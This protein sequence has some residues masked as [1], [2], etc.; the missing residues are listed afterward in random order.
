MSK[1][2]NEICTKTK[3]CKGRQNIRMR[4]NRHQRNFT[5]RSN[6]PA[7]WNYICRIKDSTNGLSHH[8]KLLSTISPHG[9]LLLKLN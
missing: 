6:F 8:G 9:R 1:S 3:H 4:I 5:L 2:D 7:E